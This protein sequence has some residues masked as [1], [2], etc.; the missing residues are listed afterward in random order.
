MRFKNRIFAGQMLAEALKKYNHDPEA[1]VI[2]LPRGGVVPAYEIAHQLG[3]PLD[4]IIVR[5]IG[6]PFEPE[7]AVG[8]LSEDGIILFN[9]DVLDMLRLT[10]E[11]MRD[12]VAQ[13]LE[14]ASKRRILFRAGK[15]PIDLHGKTVI[16]VDD[17]VA[18]G[19][20]LRVAIKTAKKRGAHR[21]VVALPVAPTEFKSQIA[22]EVD[23]AIILSESDFFPGVGYF[24]DVFQQVEDQEV[25]HLLHISHS[26]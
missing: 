8:A 11:D 13:K 16:I 1:V 10:R 26:L 15:E 12:A 9:D 7:L 25:L 20:T 17:G 14:E 21:I 24:Y 22:S 18:T 4:I 23:E 19:A 2:G 6:A 5:K 3:L